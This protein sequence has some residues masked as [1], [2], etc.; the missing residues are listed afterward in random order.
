MTSTLSANI[1]NNQPVTNN[2]QE[3]LDA[4][5]LPEV[6]NMIKSLSEFGLAVF[7]P[8]LHDE[9]GVFKPLPDNLVTFEK[10]QFTS[11]LPKD[12]PKSKEGLPVAWRW[13]KELN[14]VAF[15]NSCVGAHCN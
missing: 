14:E 15:C 13:D 3:S 5:K 4:I 8:H 11:F 2:I 9:D 6:Q 7:L 1:I 12:D 10:G